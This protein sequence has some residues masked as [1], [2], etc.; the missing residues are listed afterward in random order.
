MT[1][2]TIP[3]VRQHEPR[4]CGA[5]ALAM[6]Y[7]S[8]GLACSQEEV[9]EQ[10][11][12]AGIGGFRR[13]TTHD[14]AGDVVRRGLNPLVLRARDPW[15]ICSL[16]QHGEVRVVLNHRL[17]PASPS[18][19]FSV[20]VDM[21]DA[22]ITL[23]DPQ[24]GPER[25]LSR[26]EFL[27]LWQPASLRSEVPGFILLAVCRKSEPAPPCVACGGSMPSS[28]TCPGCEQ[29][30]ALQPAAMLGCMAESCRG[31]AW[32]ELFCPHCDFPQ[33]L[34]LRRRRGA[35]AWAGHG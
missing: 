6:V 14:L 27:A 18:G 12:T 34:F 19:H 8:L 13:C 26:A 29:S 35:V 10:A 7:Q 31:R 3:Y 15:Q 23:H 30:F 9:W 32:D 22:S 21:D 25:R 20:L 2:P 4:G 5:A 33:A 24:I 28:I 11:A 1:A 17:E 16:G